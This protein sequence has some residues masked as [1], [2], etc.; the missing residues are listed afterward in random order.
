MDPKKLLQNGSFCIYPFVHQFVDVDHTVKLCCD[1]DLHVGTVDQGINT[2]W[3]SQRLNDVRSDMIAGKPVAG[4]HNCYLSEKQNRTSKRLKD[5]IAWLKNNTLDLDVTGLPRYY[6]LRHTNLCNL[7]CRMCFPK[8]STSLNAEVIRIGAPMEPF[9]KSKGFQNNQMT[10]LCET[11]SQSDDIKKIYLAGGEPSIDPDMLDI[12]EKLQ[13]KDIE[14]QISTNGQEFNDKFL[15]SIASIKNLQLVFS[16]DGPELVNNYIRYP[17]DF[18]KAID[19]LRWVYQ[20]FGPKI[21]VNFTRQATNIWYLTDFIDYFDA[22]PEVENVLMHDLHTPEWMSYSVIP[23]D[24]KQDIIGKIR[25]HKTSK[26]FYNIQKKH[27]IDKLENTPY[28]NLLH[29][30]FVQYNKI[31][32]QHR[33]T[34]WPDY[35]PELGKLFKIDNQI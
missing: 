25:S 22:M 15:K 28:N 6:D 19:N 27:T 12:L 21:S 35:V 26:L 3:N 17:A 31:L 16:F 10:T 34:H 9:H 1:N 23:D 30:K 20:Q 33:G 5:S 8:L 13:H 18:N 4:C 2:L 14:W 24:F 29:K 11:I 32:D 7:K